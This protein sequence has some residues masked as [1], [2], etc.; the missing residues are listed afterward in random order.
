MEKNDFFKREI[1]SYYLLD[2]GQQFRSENNKNEGTG[3]LNV[4]QN[5]KETES[6]KTINKAKEIVSS[7]FIMFITNILYKNH[8]LPEKEIEYNGEMIP[9]K[10]GEHKWNVICMPREKK[11]I[12][13]NMYMFSKCIYSVFENNSL[14]KISSVGSG[15]DYIK[16]IIN[17]QEN[18]ASYIGETFDTCQFDVN[19]ISGRYILLVHDIYRKGNNDVEDCIETLYMLGAKEVIFLAIARAGS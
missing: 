16:R 3:F 11:D 18:K 12:P 19:K 7:Y 5:K 14:K 2:Y 15:R 9:S 17:T 4:L 1:I 13:D 10:D 6:E 8:K